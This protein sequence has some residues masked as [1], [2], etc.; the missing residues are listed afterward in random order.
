NN[1][2][3]RE[4]ILPGGMT[5]VRLNERPVFYDG[6]EYK[7]TPKYGDRR[8]IDA[9]IEIKLFE[10]EPLYL[11]QILN[12]AGTVTREK[13]EPISLDEVLSKDF[14][15]DSYVNWTIAEAEKM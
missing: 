1:E 13:T 9:E 6:M 12:T 3:T 4:Y 11:R 10:E 8:R 2:N 15:K 14:S 5:R 7:R